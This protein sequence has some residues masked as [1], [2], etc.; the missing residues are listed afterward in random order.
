MRIQK[1]LEKII[2]AVL[3]VFIAIIT[4]FAFL[5]VGSIETK[6]Y[7]NPIFSYLIVIV[8]ASFLFVLFYRASLFI[9]KLTRKQIIICQAIFWGIVI[10]TQLVLVFLFDVTQ[11]TDALMINDEA[12]SIALGT[13]SKISN[14]TPYFTVYQ[15]NDFAVIIQ[16][17]FYKLIRFF[18]LSV[19]NINYIEL[20]NVVFIDSSIFFL[21]RTVKLIKNDK[22]AVKVLLFS[23]FNPFNY[24]LIFWSYTLVYSLPLTILIV[25]LGVILLKKQLKVWQKA[26]LCGFIMVL[27]V[28]GYY[29][30]PTIIIPTIA[31]FVYW[32][33]RSKKEKP[34]V[35]GVV[36]IIGAMAIAAAVTVGAVRIAHN[37]YEY[38][39]S[40]RQ[41]PLSHWIM[42]GLSENGAISADDI[43]ITFVEQ[44]S[45][46]MQKAD[47]EEIK[48]RMSEYNVATFAKHLAVK[49]GVTWSDG[50]GNIEGFL[51]TDKKQSRLWNWIGGERNDL[52]TLFSQAFRIFV[53]LLVLYNVALQ[54]RYPRK[55]KF[56]PIF[57]IILFGAILFYLLWESKEIYS[58]PFI[59]FMFI[60]G[61][62]GIEHLERKEKSFIPMR[63]ISIGVVCATLVLGCVGINS[64]CFKKK[65]WKDYS[66][67]TEMNR[68][69]LYKDSVSTLSQDNMVIKQ[70][71]IPS[72]PFSSVEIQCDP[73]ISPNNEKARDLW[74]TQIKH[75][76]CRYLIRITDK[77][78]NL[79]KSQRVR[80]SDI[81]FENG[82]IKLDF[83]T[84]KAN[85]VYR[86]IIS[87]DENR[88]MDTIRWGWIKGNHTN[89]YPGQ[90]Y[91]NKGEIPDINIR[92]YEEYKGTYTTLPKYLVSLGAILLIE[93]LVAISYIKNVKKHHKNSEN[94]IKI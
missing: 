45:K 55:Y 77:D 9:D 22:F 59:P 21:W 72:K 74:E 84:Q 24:L 41:F 57:G 38:G 29:V 83:D 32:L 63:A 40:S 34:N 19:N 18:G 93:L 8:L 64:M 15:N 73:I 46:D 78:G 90:G 62:Y 61:T 4:V 81:D 39:K 89:Q 68:F 27:T 50:S 44:N 11:V 48:R 52:F 58:V 42:M 69:F 17:W 85:K 30:R 79:I 3:F 12:K 33:L 26:L 10:I 92:V 7:K 87:P 20:F 67:S 76:L 23:L 60:L 36:L 28:L 14:T 75:S 86:I 88:D 1:A 82:L 53:L 43:Y 71:F 51:Q 35:K 31:L 16:I 54:I 65:E 94:L 6:M 2:L 37:T 91:L 56:R 13:S 5:K 70:N 25:Y 47:I 80:V 66:I 49:M